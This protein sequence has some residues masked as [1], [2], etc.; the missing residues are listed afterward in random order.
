MAFKRSSFKSLVREKKEFFA[1]NY[2]LSKKITWD[3]GSEC[4]VLMLGLETGFYETAVHRIRTHKIDGQ[5]IGFGNSGYDV[6]IKCKGIDEEG[7]K[8]P[9]LCCQLAKAEKERT[10]KPES[11]CLNFMSTRVHIPILILGNSLKEEKPS[12]PV[13]KVS[14]LNA[15]NSEKGLNFAYLDMA[16]SSFEKDVVQ[17]YGK[18]LKE[19]GI[20][21]YEADESSEEYLD[22]IRKRLINTVVKIKAVRKAGFNQPLKEYSFF[23]F[24]NPAVASQSPEGERE[25][26]VNYKK[27]KEIMAKVDEFLTLF[28]IEVD[29]LCNEWTE[30][31]L[32][33]YYNSFVGK[34]LKD[35]GTA[36][37]TTDEKV[38]ILGEEEVPFANAEAGTAELDTSLLD[39]DL[40]EPV[41][42][43]PKKVE[44][45][46]KETPKPV[47]TPKA[48]E[49][50]VEDIEFDMEDE[51]EFFAD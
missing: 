46:V 40:E 13:S 28:G 47:E 34:A 35:N 49:V 6:Y 38:E 8:I 3:F 11:R 12:Y 31:D 45:V 18:K 19:D 16:A 51:E 9:S 2:K 10:D 7:N 50:E 27:N 37:E 43:E 1:T 20:I 15:L 22:D 29:N 33:E 41:K 21:D 26:I 17:A 42:E 25:A 24:D 44:A 48:K 5:T 23:P 36:K 30:K 4:Y 39:G 14:I 32:Q